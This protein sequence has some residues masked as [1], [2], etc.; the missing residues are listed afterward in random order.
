MTRT[1]I[2]TELRRLATGLQEAKGSQWYLFGSVNRGAQH[3][4]DIDVLILCNSDQQADTLRRLI[5]HASLSLPLHLSL[6]T[7]DEASAIAAVRMQGGTL[8]LSI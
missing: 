2:V 4:E 5:D 1:G 7:F 6:M 8:L 3:P